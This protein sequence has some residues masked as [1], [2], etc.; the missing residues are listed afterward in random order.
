MNAAFAPESALTVPC[1]SNL[2]REVAD[3]EF[4]GYAG[5]ILYVDLTTGKIR[6]QELDLEVA[7]KFIG[8]FGL[9][10]YLAYN[11]IKPRTNA[12]S[13][14]NVVVIGAGPFLG[15]TIT[16]ASKV[17]LTTKLPT[18]VVGTCSGSIKFGAML[19]WA[20]YDHVVITGQARRPVYLKIFDDIVEIC[21]AG[22]LW[23]RD[24]YDTT[25]ELW[26]RHG[27]TCS[28]TAI[29][30][31]SENL[32]VPSLALIDKIG[33]WGRSAGAVLGSKKLKA[34]V[35]R[36]T[37]GIKVARKKEFTKLTGDIIKR[38]M[39]Y[40]YR[41]GWVDW[42]LMY[43]WDRWAGAV[44]GAQSKNFRELYPADKVYKSFG[45]DAISSKLNKTPIACASCTSCDKHMVEVKEGEYAGLETYYSTIF[46]LALFGLAWNVTLEEKVKIHDLYQ[47]YGLDVI[48]TDPMIDW[49][50]ELFERGII[51]EKDTGGLSLNH[52]YD[53]LAE[54]LEQIAYRKGFGDVLAD[55]WNGA[56]KRIGKGCGQ[57][58][59]VVKD[60]SPPL[61]LRMGFGT[62][63]LDGMVNPRA[64]VARGG[65][66]TLLS[67]DV[68][69]DLFKK[70][71]EKVGV[72]K[73]AQSRIF[74]PDQ[75]VNIARATKYAENWMS[76]FDSL[77]ICGRATINR[78]YND[79][80]IA[81]LYSSLT[82]IGLTPGEIV[83][84]GERAWNLERALC[85]REGFGRKDDKIPERFLKEPLK[86][87]DKDLW[88]QDY[89]RTK[90]RFTKD[91]FKKMLDDYYDERGWDIPTGIP[92]KN[93]FIELG[94]DFAAD[95]LEVL[96]KSYE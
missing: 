24:L 69:F 93:K 47:R 79:R 95:D 41:D 43:Y 16:G 74:V 44:G 28:I 82:G 39:D 21:D 14:D 66:P 62:D 65:S 33:H 12:L 83:Q 37:R 25:D 59:V 56:I 1:D 31:A 29:G 20:G 71:G 78:L 72:P 57:Y 10:A 15:T 75:P 77:G 22:D 27:K 35:V 26:E 55:G 11:L 9:N 23:G 17:M 58:A 94:L 5:R 45:P 92:S 80:T 40:K 96:R 49:A 85:A 60:A 18:G 91:D 67:A 7:K 36:G 64:Q 3:M 63:G 90:E 13:E 88:L 61:D 76:L 53:C 51:S 68:P 38:S 42:G 89:F 4:Y 6:E 81:D 87:K 48:T 32:V 86:A 46:D 70:W 50:I 8:G 30:Q 34:M 54:L 19:K 52:N 73:E 84:A 2:N